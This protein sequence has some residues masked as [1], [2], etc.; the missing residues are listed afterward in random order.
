VFNSKLAPNSDS[1]YFGS[2]QLLGI[3][4]APTYLTTFC[5]RY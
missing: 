4:L 1:D 3:Q 5:I 2:I